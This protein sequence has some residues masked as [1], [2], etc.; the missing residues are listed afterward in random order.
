MPRQNWGKIEP[1][2]RLEDNTQNQK[3]KQI[4]ID[5]LEEK[6]EEKT[7]EA[8]QVAPLK[9]KLKNATVQRDYQLKKSCCSKYT[10]LL[11]LPRKT[12]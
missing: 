7:A 5:K 12:K 4:E 3:D 1:N 9:I 8:E 2:G 11:V 6:L 10:L